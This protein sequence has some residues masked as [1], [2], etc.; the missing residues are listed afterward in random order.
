MRNKIF[1]TGWIAQVKKKER[2]KEKAF[3]SILFRREI[4]E[5]KA[6]KYCVA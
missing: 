1:K 6:K 4:K 3:F 5:K 2:E